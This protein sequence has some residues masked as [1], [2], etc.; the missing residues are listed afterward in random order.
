[1][2]EAARV[3]GVRLF[4]IGLSTSIDVEA[5][6]QLATAGGGAMLYADTVE[7]LITL[8]GSLGKLVS[9]GLPTYRLRFAIDAGEPGVFASGQTVLARARVQLRGQTVN[10]PMAVGVP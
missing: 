7:Q 2:I 4:T 10:S 6:S 5:L 1:M 9:L 3:D 8:H